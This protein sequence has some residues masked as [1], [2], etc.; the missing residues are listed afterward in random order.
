MRGILHG[1]VEN[2]NEHVVSVDTSCDEEETPAISHEDHV[3]EEVD[4]R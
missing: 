3:F 4:G 1:L 2:V